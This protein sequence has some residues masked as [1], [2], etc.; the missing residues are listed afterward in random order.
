VRKGNSFDP[1][2][3]RTGTRTIKLNHVAMKQKNNALLWMLLAFFTLALTAPAQAQDDLYYDPA[4]DKTVT[5]TNNNND[6]YREEGSNV[7]RRYNGDDQYSDEDD[8]AYEYSS[9]IRRFHRPTQVIDYYDP[10]Y[11]DLYNYDPYFLPGTTIYTYG[12]N[13][14]WT[15]RRWQ[16]WNRWNRWKCW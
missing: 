6:D 15:W 2:N 14:Y 9:R 10:Y 3:L 16:R 5:P 1:V 7:T 4:T 13:D 8:Y 11:V 12:Y